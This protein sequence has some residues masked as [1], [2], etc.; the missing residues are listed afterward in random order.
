MQAHGETA[1]AIGRRFFA[2]Q[3]RLHGGP[4]PELCAAGYVAVI[5]GNPPMDRDGHERFAKGFYAAFPDIT[6][7]IDEAFAEDGRV[8]VRFTLNGTHT[9]SF[10]GMPPTGKTVR[11]SANIV[12]FISE[13]KVTKLLGVFDEAGLLRQLG[14]LPG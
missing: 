12:M 5:G 9:G 10:F 8:A 14:V 2:E 7:T 3:D 6:H 1:A 4:A 13:G 11:V